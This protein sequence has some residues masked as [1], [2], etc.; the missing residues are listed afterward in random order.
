[1]RLAFLLHW[2]SVSVMVG[3]CRE[4]LAYERVMNDRISMTTGIDRHT[5]PAV[6]HAPVLPTPAIPSAKKTTAAADKLA[7][8]PMANLSP[9]LLASISAW[10]SLAAFSTGPA[11]TASAIARM[12]N[13]APGTICS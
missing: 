11:T 12:R 13:A 2:P 5:L 1:M 7:V 3:Q 6:M 4:S 10:V 8:S 9:R